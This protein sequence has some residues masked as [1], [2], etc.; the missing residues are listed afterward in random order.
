MPATYKKYLENEH[1]Y[2]GHIWWK[3]KDFKAS[4]ESYIQKMRD[5]KTYFIEDYM[6]E[7]IATGEFDVKSYDQEM[8]YI[9]VWLKD[10]LK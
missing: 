10:I 7:I 5:P 4:I 9:Y 2:Y 3:I 8:H 6:Q 1:D